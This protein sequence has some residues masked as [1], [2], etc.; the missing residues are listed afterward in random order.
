MTNLCDAPFRLNLELVESAICSNQTISSDIQKP[1][2]TKSDYHRAC[3][4]LYQLLSPSTAK[5][6]D[7]FH[8]LLTAIKNSGPDV[9]T[10]S[11]GGVC[12]TATDGIRIRKY[13]V[14]EDGCV[15]DLEFHHYKQETLYL[16]EG[17]GFV[18][19]NNK[20]NTLDVT[21]LTSESLLITPHTVHGLLAT[22]P[23]VVFEDSMEPNGM[24]KD[25][26]W[27]F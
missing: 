20:P 17:S 19:I 21:P 23:L 14:V 5:E 3:S 27:F 9:I 13:L 10:T 18:L 26:H 2:Y 8:Q 22:S 16:I 1:I 24:D 4:A 6:G 12:L 7:R 11:W 25:I 15:L